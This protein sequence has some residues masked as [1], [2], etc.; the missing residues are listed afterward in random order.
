MKLLVGAVLDRREDGDMRPVSDAQVRMLMEEMSKHGQVGRAAMKADMD[1]KT[2]RKYVAAGQVPSSMTKARTWLTRENPFADV[3]HE[4]EEL[5]V[6]EPGLDAKTVFEVLQT[7]HPGRF[8][9]G[10]VRTLQ[11]HVRKWRA[12][13]GPDVDVTFVQRHR[14][15]EAMQTDFTSVAE[16]EVIIVGEPL[17]L[18]QLANSTLPYSNWR[19]AT[20][21]ASESM[22]AI[23]QGVQRALFQLGRV[24]EWHQTDHSTAATHQLPKAEATPTTTRA[25]NAEYVALMKHFGMKPRTIEVGEKEQNGDVEASNGALK[26]ALKQALLVRGS[27]EFE[28]VAAWQS[29]VD[30]VCRKS[31]KTKSAKVEE[32]FAVMRELKAEK[33]AEWIEERVRVTSSSTVSVKHALYSVPSRLIGETVRVRVFEGRVEVWFDD[34][35]QLSCERVRGQHPRRI[36]YRHV[37]SSLV[38]KPGAFERYIFRDDMFPTSTFRQAF[39]ALKVERPN[40]K[41]DLEY[42][43]ILHLAARTMEAE[44]E[45]ALRLFLDEKLPITADGVK[46]LVE[47]KTR[48]SVPSLSTPAVDLDSY[49]SFVGVSA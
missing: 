26:R 43:R 20:S 12:K 23:R 7:R 40:V 14:P 8:V 49:D 38:K 30:D 31:N 28:S 5:M 17:G 48:P 15:G 10:Q 2:A 45:A 24:P 4:V 46:E 33:L 3:W 11:R 22:A 27:R 29:F 13:E 1:R 18:T 41:G 19:W 16:L 36:D 34:E 35:L 44:V 9:D 32:E 21:C 6:G 39:D 42:I 37:I 47:Q 25:F